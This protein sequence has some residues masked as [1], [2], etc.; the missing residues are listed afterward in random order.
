MRPASLALALLLSTAPLAAQTTDPVARAAALFERERYAQVEALLAPYVAANPR[1]ARAA[2]YLGRAHLRRDRPD[3]AATLL[4][5][6]ARLAPDSSRFH[7]ALAEAYGL[8]AMKAN[9]VQQ[10]LLAR[11]AK[12]AFDRAVAADPD[13]AEA[14][15]GL[16][17]FHV[18]APA[19]MGG[20]RE[21]AMRHAAEVKRLNPY[22]GALATAIV[23]RAGKDLAAAAG[24]LEAAMRR[25]PDSVSARYALWTVRDEQGDPE[26]AREVLRGIVRRWPEEMLAVYQIGR[27]GA[28]H[29]GDLEEAERALLRYLRHTPEAGQ[30]PLAAAHW[31][32]G[33]VHERQGRIDDARADYEAALRLDPKQED[34]KRALARLRSR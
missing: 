29:G 18:R 8:K 30:P 10:A 22:R 16:V 2:Y 24:E 26:G 4:E 12:G 27:A 33:M 32:L 21:Q 5:R 31:R 17:Q 13:N 6:A 3:D 28:M 15:Y 11:R 7:L 23:H 1:D 19:V 34:A 14:H 20:S 9:V 25:F